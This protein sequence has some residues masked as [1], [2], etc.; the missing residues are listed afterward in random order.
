M[1]IGLCLEFYL[2]IYIRLFVYFRHLLKWHTGYNEKSL[3][4]V[5][6]CQLYPFA[7]VCPSVSAAVVH[8]YI[9][10]YLVAEIVSV[11]ALNIL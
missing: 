1:N 3:L 10:C 4:A 2:F 8:T 5:I 7:V 6:H 9:S 11:L